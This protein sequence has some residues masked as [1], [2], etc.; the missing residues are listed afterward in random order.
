MHLHPLI[1]T[2]LVRQHEL[3][4][5][6]LTLRAPLSGD[7]ARRSLPSKTTAAGI[8]SLIIAIFATLA[9]TTGAYA[10]TGKKA[11]HGK[12]AKSALRASLTKPGHGPVRIVSPQIV[13]LYWPGPAQPISSSIDNSY[14][15]CAYYQAN[16]TDQ[17]NCELW[18]DNCERVTNPTSDSEP[19]EDNSISDGSTATTTQ[20]ASATTDPATEAIGSGDGSVTDTTAN[21]ADAQNDNQNC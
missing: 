14:D 19:A 10:A 18:G 12:S 6:R 17:Q 3:E 15:D 1:H 16:C 7:R 20:T 4:L 11:P 2:E 13:H 8:A 5:S 21:L 9:L